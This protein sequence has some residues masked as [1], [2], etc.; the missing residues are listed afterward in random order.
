MQDVRKPQTHTIS[1]IELPHTAGQ[2]RVTTRRKRA[3][4]SSTPQRHL[5]GRQRSCVAGKPPCARKSREPH[6]NKNRGRARGRPRPSPPA[7]V[8]GRGHA[9][10][11]AG[12]GVPLATRGGLRVQRASGGHTHAARWPAPVGRASAVRRIALG[13]QRVAAVGL[14]CGWGVRFAAPCCASQRRC[15]NRIAPGVRV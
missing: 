2:H 15:G 11:D 3:Q 13:T 9:A 7:A 1:S 4:P 6:V 8:H 5:K 12:K 10:G 14:L